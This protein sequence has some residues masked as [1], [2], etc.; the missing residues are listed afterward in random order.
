M[1]YHYICLGGI[2]SRLALL[3]K[4]KQHFEFAHFA[5]LSHSRTKHDVN[6]P[7]MYMYDVRQNGSNYIDNPLT[8]TEIKVT[9]EEKSITRFDDDSKLPLLYRSIQPLESENVNSHHHGLFKTASSIGV[10]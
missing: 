6:M 10:R 7:E 8:E 4:Y 9:R 3:K 1:P 5:P 2:D